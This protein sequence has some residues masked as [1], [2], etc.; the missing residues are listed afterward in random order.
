MPEPAAVVRPSARVLLVDSAERVLL[1]RGADPDRPD[2][3]FW[4]TPG[5]GIEPEESAA[6]AARRELREETGLA[7][8]ALGPLVWTRVARFTFSGTRY[9]AHES[10]FLVRCAPFE[11]DTSGLTPLERRSHFEHRWWGLAEMTE[12]APLT[13][14]PDLAEQL[15][16]LLREGPPAQPVRVGGAVLP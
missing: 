7:L 8:D 9:E 12:A 1:F 3:S 5:G 14:P 11:V 2:R 6:E 10:Y 4:F 13:A 15:G 16:L